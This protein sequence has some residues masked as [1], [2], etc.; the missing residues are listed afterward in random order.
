MFLK[1][2]Y[3]I[4]LLVERIRILAAWTLYSIFHSTEY[5]IVL[6]RLEDKKKGGKENVFALISIWSVPSPKYTHFS[7]F[8]IELR[9]TSC[10]HIPAHHIPSVTTRKKDITF[11]TSAPM[12]FVGHSLEFVIVLQ[13]RFYTTAF[14]KNTK[15]HFCPLNFEF[16]GFLSSYLFSFQ[17]ISFFS[18][19]MVIPLSL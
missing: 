12:K 2:I 3:K 5:N 14:S 11:E 19:P 18:K 1:D 10:T 13:S 16:T 17:A 8:T 4:I 6:E 9:R 7:I 15:G